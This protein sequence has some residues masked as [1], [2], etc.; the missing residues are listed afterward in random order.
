ME[1]LE[2]RVRQLE[3]DL[4]ETQCEL[5]T[6]RTMLGLIGRYVS[7]VDLPSY[8]LSPKRTELPV[9]LVGRRGRV[10]GVD[11]GSGRVYVGLTGASGETVRVP[12]RAVKVEGVV[13]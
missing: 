9:S 4:S 5:A 6:L 13:G 3:L 8:E 12:V 7:I 1:H 11:D 10:L 2:G